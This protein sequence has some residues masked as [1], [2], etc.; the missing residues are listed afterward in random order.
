MS[1][2]GST[3]RQFLE[4]ALASGTLVLLGGVPRLLA[5]VPA[6]TRKLRVGLV[7][8][9]GASADGAAVALGVRFAAE[10][11][12]HA[13]GLVGGSFELLEATA[14]DPKAAAREAARLASKEKVTAV[15][16]GLDQHTREAVTEVAERLRFVFLTTRAPGDVPPPEPVRAHQLHLNTPHYDLCRALSR[17]LV[18]EA[19]L[20]SW[21]FVGTAGEPG[22]FLTGS[23]RQTHLQ[24][25]GT[26]AGVATVDPGAT[27]FAPLLEQIA[28]ARPQVVF[29]NV[30]E[31][32][33]SRLLAALDHAGP[34][35][36]TVAVTGPFPPLGGD[37][38]DAP[39]PRREIWPVLW[40][41]AVAAG[42]A[43]ELNQRF[44]ARLNRPMGSLAWMGWAA[45]Q[46]LT[47]LALKPADPAVTS[48]LPP[49]ADLA[50][51]LG[52]TPFDGHKV[53][54]LRFDFNR[55][56]RQPLYL[57]GS[58]PGAPPGPLALL[59]KVEPEKGG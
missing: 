49:G 18:S 25:A 40:H 22:A 29:L 14:A 51:R 59:G 13:L 7:L 52:V 2:P 6:P 17:Y 11:V 10:E 15:I 16:G 57:V 26:L 45:V 33:V 50:A 8:P 34:S 41:P 32:T 1:D 47:S 5:A 27:S 43:A 39:T 28:K 55:F 9:G 31:P 3:R 4:G 37:R 12:R 48:S 44:Q 38:M 54:P 35:L 36:A 53:T 46:A 20:P 21:F 24:N 23:A 30:G 42:G 58:K 56:L 19:H